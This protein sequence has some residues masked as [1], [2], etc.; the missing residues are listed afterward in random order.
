MADRNS[1]IYRQSNNSSY[2]RHMGDNRSA[3]GMH[4]RSNQPGRQT[5]YGPAP[6]EFEDNFP[7]EDELEYVDDFDHLSNEDGQVAHQQERPPVRKPK[8]FNKPQ[9]R[10]TQQY[11]RP[12]QP[13]IVEPEQYDEPYDPDFDYGYEPEPEIYVNRPARYGAVTEKSG[14][15]TMSFLLMTVGVIILVLL[16]FVFTF[17]TGLNMG[18]R[19]GGESDS[20]GLV[21]SGALNSQ[22]TFSNAVVSRGSLGTGRISPFF[23]PSVQYWED[24]IV[25][26]AERHNLDPNIIATIMQVESCGDPQALSSAGAM[27]L[28]QVMPYHFNA[29]EDAYVPDINALRGMN[30]MA[31]R[32]IQTG[33]DVGKAFAG[34]NGGQAAAASSWSNWANETQ[35][36]YTW[37]T[38]IYGDSVNGNSTS[39]TLTQ[40]YAAGGTSLCN[41]A[42]SRLGITE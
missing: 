7:Y 37:T 26:W 5:G 2:G 28:F 21:E 12:P 41:Q 14:P 6:E 34:Y 33:G 13:R 25:I 30:Y 39:D 20:A 4:A 27:G 17:I 16:T 18:S 29:G 36:Y 35:R 9:A 15:P 23:A 32:L 8:T 1:R 22:I 31:E 3:S 10:K 11:R 19:T 40:W 42:E 38:G 24:E